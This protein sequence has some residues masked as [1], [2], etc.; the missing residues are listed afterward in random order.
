MMSKKLIVRIA[1]AEYK[2]ICIIS[3]QGQITLGEGGE[4]VERMIF[5]R[6]AEG[7]RQMVVDL[8]ET[9]FLD[10][11]G[12]G[13]LAKG[14]SRVKLRTGKAVILPSPKVKEVFAITKLDTFFDLSASLE[15]ALAKIQGAELGP[16]P[17]LEYHEVYSVY[18]IGEDK[19]ASYERVDE[20]GPVPL[21]GSSKE[22]G[23]AESSGNRS[24]K[25]DHPP[26]PLSSLVVAT[27]LG[28]V[29]FGA[30]IVGL[31]WVARQISS[32]WALSLIFAVA[33]L[34]TINIVVFVLVVSGFLSEKSTE[35]LLSGILG[36]VPGLKLWLPSVASRKTP[37]A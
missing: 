22:R 20:I 27:L 34:F 16:V 7:V 33:I 25:G 1:Q 14:I 37:A 23:A 15:D 8:R 10:S 36:K 11:S 5:V 13:G 32:P 26:L 3:V 21:D 24:A 6:I 19:D 17:D 28:L 4:A 9:T 12:I 18:R 29:I 31:V 30:I 35:R 2:G